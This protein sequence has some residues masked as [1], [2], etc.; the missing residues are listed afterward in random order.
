MRNQFFLASGILGVELADTVILDSAG[1]FKAYEFM[2]GERAC[3]Q[4]VITVIDVRSRDLIVDIGGEGRY[5]SE[6]AFNWKPDPDFSTTRLPLLVQA[7]TDQWNRNK[8]PP[9]PLVPL[10]YKGR[11]QALAAGSPADGEIPGGVF[12]PQTV[13]KFYLERIGGYAYD[14]ATIAGMLTVIRSGGT[15]SYCD[16]G[17]SK[18]DTMRERLQAEASKRGMMVRVIKGPVF[19]NDLPFSSYRAPAYRTE[20]QIFLKKN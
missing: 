1:R 12:L 4:N 16:A 3:I 7:L 6:R 2:G 11:A 9:T 14:R 5:L 20:F 13:H 10:H 15:I 17:E 8:K 19:L 18:S